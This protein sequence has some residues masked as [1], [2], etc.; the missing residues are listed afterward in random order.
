MAL[1]LT[2]RGVPFIPQF[3]LPVTYKGTLLKA[4]YKPDFVCYESVVVEL[5]A[6]SVLGG[7]EEAQ[8]LNYLKAMGHQTGLLLNFGT[9]SLQYKRFVRS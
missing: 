1:E 8:L 2:S 6:L 9:K 3:E 7:V 5:K 4:T